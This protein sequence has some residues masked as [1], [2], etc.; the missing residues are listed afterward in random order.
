MAERVRMSEY[1]YLYGQVFRQMSK[2]SLWIPLLAHGVLALGLALIHYYI[3]SPVTGPL[4]K[5]WVKVIDAQYASLFYH[6][7]IHFTLLPYFFGTA[8]QVLN[9]LVE[10]FLFGIVL[11]LLISL[12]RGERPAFMQS[13]SRAFRRYVQL[14][15]VWLVLISVLYVINMNF[16]DFVETI[17]GYS[18]QDA[19]RRQMMAQFAARGITILIY[20]LFVFML[21]S[22][23]AGGMSFFGAVKRGFRLFFRHPFAAIGLVLIPYLIGFFPS[24]ALSNPSKIVANFNP[25]VVFYLV[26]VSIGIDVVVNFI[27][28]GTSLKFFMDQST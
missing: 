23:M 28:L 18:L 7:P 25:E 5:V 17:L 27:L 3:F 10:A 19:P 24:W 26:L 16:S 4:V 15:V 8:Q 20:A 13:L 11:D 22:I 14:T 6:Y 9:I 2:V 1:W 12:Y 21:P